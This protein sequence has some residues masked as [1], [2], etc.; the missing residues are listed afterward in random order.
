L[1][2]ES[3]N[4]IASSEY[5]AGYHKIEASPAPYFDMDEESNVQSVVAELIKKE[6][7]VSAHDC[8][9]GGLFISLLESAMPKGLGFRV[10]LNAD[11]RKDAFLFGEAQGRVVVSVPQALFEDFMEFI[12][13]KDVPYSALGYVTAGD[14]LID[15][16]DWG[17]ASE[18]QTPYET[19]LEKKLTE[20]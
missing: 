4:D 18:F 6:L 10:N 3:Q 14:I 11:I 12:S 17:S 8:A 19:I 20:K 16:E 9:D 5:L 1:I 7:I 2:G 13:E 15:D